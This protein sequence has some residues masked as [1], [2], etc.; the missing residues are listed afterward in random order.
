MRYLYI[1]VIYGS[2]LGIDLIEWSVSGLVNN[3]EVYNILSLLSVLDV[4]DI[5]DMGMSPFYLN[6][7]Q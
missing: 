3:C 7:T 4:L 1:D 5:E 6:F 2:D